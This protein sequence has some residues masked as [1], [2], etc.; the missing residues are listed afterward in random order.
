M[1][2]EI[3]SL[4]SFIPGSG[5]LGSV[6][7]DPSLETTL[8][9]NYLISVSSS[10]HGRVEARIPENISLTINSEWKSLIGDND[11][12]GSII[13]VGIQE[14]LNKAPTTQ[15]MTAQVWSGNAPIELTLSLEF[16]AGYNPQFNKKTAAGSNGYDDVIK[17][18]KMLSKM[19]LPSGGKG[20]LLLTPPGPRLF[21]KTNDKGTG[22]VV[23]EGGAG[24]TITIEVGKFLTFERVII[25]NVSPEFSGAMSSDGY[26]MSAKVDVTFRTLYSLVTEQVDNMFKQI[27]K[28]QLSSIDNGKN[29]G[30]SLLSY[31]MNKFNPSTSVA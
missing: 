17:P 1:G 12:S 25:T 22:A 26:P 14:F 8:S 3:S 19:A 11:A 23:S 24:D 20:S 21:Q 4:K 5:N 31:A 27:P 10:S 16:K 28:V 18:V 6:S 13:K 7:E 30:K 9:E 2:F 15:V 29:S